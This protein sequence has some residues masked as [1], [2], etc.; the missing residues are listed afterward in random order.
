MRRPLS[1]PKT[2][3]RALIKY[4]TDAIANVVIR[5][6]NQHTCKILNSDV[7]R[8]EFACSMLYL[9]RN[10]VDC[11][12]ECI[13]PKVDIMSGILPLESFLPEFFNIRSKSITEG[14]NL[15]KIELRRIHKI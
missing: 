2:E 5:Y 13:L 8:R 15:L 3:L 1:I 14:E 9:M 10:G 7:R 12:G 6:N 4:C 11:N